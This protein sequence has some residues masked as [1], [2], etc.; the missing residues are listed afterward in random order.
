MEKNTEWR[1]EALKRTLRLKTIVTLTSYFKLLYKMGQD[2]LV[3][4]YCG[5]MPSWLE[6]LKKMGI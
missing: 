1:K 5:K 4:K 2:F 3:G 6:K